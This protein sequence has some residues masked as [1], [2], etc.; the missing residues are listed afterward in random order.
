[1]E[2]YHFSSVTTDVPQDFPF[3]WP[4]LIF[5]SL[6]RSA[7]SSPILSSIRSK[8][9]SAEAVETPAFCGCRISPRCRWT[10]VRILSISRRTKSSRM[11][12]PFGQGLLNLAENSPDWPTFPFENTQAVPKADDF[13]LSL[14]VHAIHSRGYRIVNEKRTKCKRLVVGLQADEKRRCMVGTMPARSS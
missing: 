11:A 13:S 14:R 3:G 9:A 4:R 6:S 5:F 12:F 8:S 2:S 10:W 7:Q 1:L